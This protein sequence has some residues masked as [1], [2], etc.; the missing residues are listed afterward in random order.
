KGQLL[1][2]ID[3]RPFEA[4]IRQVQG[5]IARDEAQLSQAEANL[6]R[7]MAQLEY[8]KTQTQR[9][10]T[11]TQRGLISADSSEQVKSQAA[12]L[13]QSVRADRA[14]IES[15]RASLK[16]SEGAL[17]S[18]KLQL[19]YCTINSPID[20]RTGAVMLKAGNLIKAADVPIVVIN[21]VDP[22]YVNF[23]VP[24]QYWG[25]VNKHL[26]AGD[27]HVRAT[28]PQDQDKPRE[29][30]VIF[31]DN[32]VDPT[33]GTLHI[34]A[35]FDNADNRFV[36]GMFVNVM[37]R[38]SEQPDAKVVPT[39]AVTEGQNGTFVYVV[40]PDNTVEARPVATTRSFEGEAVI[41]KGLEADET[42]V[43]D[44]LTRLTPGAKV[45][46]KNEHP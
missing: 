38:L 8:A 33:T 41:D 3:P 32:A 14:A 7:D 28:A 21:Q 34:R 40:K 2:T 12:A 20:G 1:F 45:Q 19:S 29:G 39:Q 5:N 22:I 27:L 16:G 23:T 46:I 13:D 37:L 18:A 31:V 36:S 24:Q 43:I 4:Q 25:D 35:A 42:I 9:Y 26:T 11:L 30:K 10:S 17:E 44:G 6:A 15:A